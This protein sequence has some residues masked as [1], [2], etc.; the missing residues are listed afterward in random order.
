MIENN[1]D[2]RFIGISPA[3][4]QSLR[5]AYDSFLQEYRKYRKNADSVDLQNYEKNRKE[6]KVVLGQP[7]TFFGVLNR[8]NKFIK[9]NSNDFA[10]TEN[11]LGEEHKR[12]QTFL[13]CLQ[14]TV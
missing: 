4:K 5:M 10:R 8:Q 13:E 9:I 2:K 14:G 1:L 11:V 3:R 6:A 12:R 7:S